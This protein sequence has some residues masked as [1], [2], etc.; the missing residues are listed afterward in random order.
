[1]GK[2]SSHCEGSA[3]TWTFAKDYLPVQLKATHSTVG[4][5]SN[6]RHWFWW[7][8][9][10]NAEVVFALGAGAVEVFGHKNG[11]KSAVG[12]LVGN[13]KPLHLPSALCLD[14]CA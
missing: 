9:D 4:V 7:L 10:H 1:M 13:H 6:L 12:F 14:R 11:V 3:S 5:N 2:E 8:R